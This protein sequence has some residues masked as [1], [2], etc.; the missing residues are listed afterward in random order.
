[1]RRYAGGRS[2]GPEG[3]ADAAYVVYVVPPTNNALDALR[4]LLEAAARLA[5]VTAVGAAT[6][7]A[8]A[9]AAQAQASSTGAP[10]RLG[11]GFCQ[12]AAGAGTGDST[13]SAVWGA[14]G[15]GNASMLRQSQGTTQGLAAGLAAASSAW[16]AGSTYGAGR[17][18]NP[19]GGGGAV[20]AAP[21]GLGCTPRVGPSA[22]QVEL[23]LLAK[24]LAL[25]QQYGG[26]ARDLYTA[27][28]PS[29]DGTGTRRAGNTG[30]EGGPP[31]T[32]L[33]TGATVGL[34]PGARGAT[35]MPFASAGT[36]APESFRAAA[37]SGG[38]A[39]AAAVAAAGGVWAGSVDALLR[40]RP[41]DITLQL[42]LPS[43]LTG[44][45][46]GGA[47][48]TAL[49]VY[50]KVRR[51][52]SRVTGATPAGVTMSA[53]QRL[54]APQ[55]LPTHLP[56]PTAATSSSLTLLYEPLLSLAAEGSNQNRQGG[57]QLQAATPAA[58]EA[59]AAADAAAT[60]DAADG[61]PQP[62]VLHC[63]YEYKACGG[64]EHGMEGTWVALCWV[65]GTGQLLE[66]RTVMLR[67]TSAA[68]SAT[69]APPVDSRAQPRG[70]TGA[71]PTADSSSRC[72][73][74]SLEHLVC[75]AVLHHS[76]M[77]LQQLQST[78]A[79]AHGSEQAVSSAPGVGAMQ[80]HATGAQQS[81]P[82][83]PTLIVTRA[84]RRLP[85]G[86]SAA[87]AALLSPSSMQQ[88]LNTAEHALRAAHGSMSLASP[89]APGTPGTPDT[90]APSCPR[91][92]VTS[93]TSHSGDESL[94]LDPVHAVWPQG[95]VLICAEP[96]RGSSTV[97]GAPEGS[98]SGTGGQ[99]PG[100]KQA[101]SCAAHPAAAVLSFPSP[102]SACALAA[103]APC[104]Q[105]WAMTLELDTHPGQPLVQA[106]AQLTTQAQ[107]GLGAADVAQ[108][109]VASIAQQLHGLTS[110]AA[111]YRV[112]HAGHGTTPHGL[113]LPG[114]MARTG[115]VA[116]SRPLLPLHCQA[117]RQLLALCATAHVTLVG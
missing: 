17:E 108:P 102:V 29:A 61:G 109:V 46:A 41:L 65:D 72:G 27:L 7:S 6:V 45:D 18:G 104:V 79:Q 83:A 107:Q 60:S 48:A 106:P 110:L 112:A 95:T 86:E 66:R 34:G 103:R 40:S 22:L 55:P 20:T 15:L 43:M 98:H 37:L 49:S 97:S 30:T 1:M 91:V 71:R 51:L 25:V 67:P 100:M 5:P 59:A 31:P 33:P 52:A 13:G 90:A 47:R 35:P 11:E 78:M 26:A 42:V 82:R 117:A 105:H 111:A 14:G 94:G 36:P 88:A 23:G 85:A 75:S 77:L 50:N 19:N 53:T 81:T 115:P 12:E 63:A 68:M 44:V 76:L 24:E 80:T 96:P 93:V 3:E 32:N 64:R 101:A 99:Q 16:P 57:S 92:I 4:C 21:L 58:Q 62:L 69:E 116:A 9:C 73:N 56:A 28:L 113:T 38:A 54:R 89:P 87:W 8:A 39:A 2:L 74:Q 84:A 114:A 10:D 70:P